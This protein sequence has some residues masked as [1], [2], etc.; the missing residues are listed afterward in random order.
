MTGSVLFHVQHL[1]GIGHLQRTMRIAEALA[2]HSLDVT[3]VS[4]GMPVSL[5]VPPSVRLRQLPPVRA[6]DARFE[7]IDA[8]GAPIDEIL[9]QRRRDA[10]LAAFDDVRPDAV[11]IEG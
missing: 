3:V 4:G 5:P 8:A 2:E 9:R 6:R 7:L 11:V 10:L 1:L